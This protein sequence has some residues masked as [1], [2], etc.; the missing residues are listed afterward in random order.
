MGPLQF[1][2]AW[3]GVS[4]GFHAMP[5]KQDLRQLSEVATTPRQKRVARVLQT[6]VGVCNIPNLDFAINFAYTCLIS[7][8]I[9]FIFFR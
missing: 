2:I 6:I 3:L 1:F 9:P 5:S 8:A 4:S 7:L